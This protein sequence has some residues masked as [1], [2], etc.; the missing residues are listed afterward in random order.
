MKMVLD[1]IITVRHQYILMVNHY[2]LKMEPDIEATAA[3]QSGQTDTSKTDTLS[4]NE[5]HNHLLCKCP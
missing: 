1:N 5:K 3:S 2:I 4:K